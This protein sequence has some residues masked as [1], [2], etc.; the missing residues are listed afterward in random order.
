MMALSI[1]R[2]TIT[3]PSTNC[4]DRCIV[5][6]IIIDENDFKSPCEIH[7]FLAEILDFPEY[8]GQNLA[9]LWDCLEESNTPLRIT[10]IRS[11]EREEWFEG[12]IRV[13]RRAGDQ[14]NS[15]DLIIK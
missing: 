15:V 7:E 12:F 3:K 13:L 1:T 2:P 8:Y 9:A 14:I 6:E 4:S 10:V 11:S 5:E